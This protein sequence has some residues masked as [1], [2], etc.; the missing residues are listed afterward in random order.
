MG[1]GQMVA[2]DF[3]LTP[4]VVFSENNAGGVG[5]AVGGLLGHKAAAVARSP[6]A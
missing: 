3:V 6:A 4:A 5:G 1:G 2:A